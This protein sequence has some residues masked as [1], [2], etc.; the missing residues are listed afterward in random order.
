MKFFSKPGPYD[1]LVDLDEVRFDRERTSFLQSFGRY[2]DQLSSGT[3]LHLTRDKPLEAALIAGV[4]R[5]RAAK[6]FL[7]NLLDLEKAFEERVRVERER[8]A[9]DKNGEKIAMLENM[10]TTF[11]ADMRNRMEQFFNEGAVRRAVS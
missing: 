2:M 9:D 7:E 4:D 5:S 1:T 11:Y 8:I 3:L 6:E 10:V